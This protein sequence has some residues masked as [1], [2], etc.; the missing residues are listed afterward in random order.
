MPTMPKPVCRVRARERIN[1]VPPS[2]ER[3]GRGHSSG[4]G[5]RP[6]GGPGIQEDPLEDGAVLPSL[7]DLLDELETDAVD[8][9][10][11]E[12]L[13]QTLLEDI[14]RDLE[15]A[16][17]TAADQEST[18][19]RK[20]ISREVVGTPSKLLEPSRNEVLDNNKSLE[21]DI[22]EYLLLH[23]NYA[24]PQPKD[25]T[26]PCR[27]SPSSTKKPKNIRPKVHTK[28]KRA[29]E[30]KIISVQSE[31]KIMVQGSMQDSEVMYGS[32]DENT[33]IITI[34]VDDDSVPLNE[35]TVTN[36]NILDNTNTPVA[37]D[38]SNSLT[39][40]KIDNGNL[41]PRSDLGYESLDSP[42]SNSDMDS[43]D[44]SMSELFPSL[45]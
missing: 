15:S 3:N 41:S 26:T 33:N 12:Q 28:A 29:I 19:N 36:D 21:H 34:F 4:F 7:P 11:L 10:A 23:H 35:V 42:V 32:F 8:L 43:W 20:H 24:K 16:A 2:A 30:N 13:T 18:V 38:V 25:S 44:Q 45:L 14:A 5:L 1:R 31:N 17:Q 27:K 6:Q 22:S 37:P 39:I 9:N 40:P